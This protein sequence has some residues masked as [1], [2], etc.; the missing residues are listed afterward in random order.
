M[1][2]RL[3]FCFTMALFKVAF[4]PV[5]APCQTRHRL[6]QKAFNDYYAVITQSSATRRAKT[7]LVCVYCRLSNVSSFPRRH[8]PTPTAIDKAAAVQFSHTAGALLDSVAVMIS[9]SRHFHNQQLSRLTIQSGF[10]AQ[11]YRHFDLL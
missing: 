9:H 5:S 10:N 7:G 6:V 3:G 1:H 11:I 8:R 4:N 2:C